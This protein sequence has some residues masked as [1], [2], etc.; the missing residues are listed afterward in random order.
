MIK[1]NHDRMLTYAEFINTELNRYLSVFDDSIN[2]NRKKLVDAMK[3]STV[4]Q[5]KRLR[6]IFAIEIC[7]ILG[8]DLKDVIPAACAIEMVHAFSLIH[9]DLPAMD[10]DD[11]RRGKPSCHK[12]FDEATAILAGDSLPLYAMSLLSTAPQIK[13]EIK[14]QQVFILSSAAGF[15]GMCGG[16]MLDMC[17]IENEAELRSMAMLKTSMLFACACALGA[18]S[19]ANNFKGKKYEQMMD[20]KFIENIMTFGENFGFL[21]QVVDDILDVT[22]TT[23]RL[24]KPVGSDKAQGKKTY[25]DFFGLEGAK[26]IVKDG[27][28]GLNQAY[29]VVENMDFLLDITNEFLIQISE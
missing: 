22:S 1:E 18:Y 5:G 3:Y 27:V 23:E 20:F 2:D 24:G 13:P 4:G 25:V 9:D 28:R 14:V 10:N 11:I 21:F 16:Q 15:K 29:G 7:R 26:N 17:G 8:G 6:G 12:Q 19:A